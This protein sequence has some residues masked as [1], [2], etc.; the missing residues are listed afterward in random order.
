MNDDLSLRTL[1]LLIFALD[2]VELLLIC[3]SGGSRT[4]RQLAVWTSADDDA[5]SYSDDDD[6]VGGDGETDVVTDVCVWE[7]RFS[8]VG[9]ADDQGGLSER[10]L[11][12]WRRHGHRHRR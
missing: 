7:S 10:R 11:D 2:I 9:N 1:S 4:L 5:V 8:V 12:I 3:T 6:D